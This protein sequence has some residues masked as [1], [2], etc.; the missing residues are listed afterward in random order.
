MPAR[1]ALVVRGMFV[2]A[3]GVTALRE[4]MLRDSPKPPNYSHAKRSSRPSRLREAV[5]VVDGCRSADHNLA[6]GNGA[7]SEGGVR[8]RASRRP[9]IGLRWRA[10]PLCGTRPR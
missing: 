2:P 4:S 8:G 1:G 3:E 6:P 9:G 10:A 5:R 7:E